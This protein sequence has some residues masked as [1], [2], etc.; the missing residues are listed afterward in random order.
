MN[1]FTAGLAPAPG[2]VPP[3]ALAG[4]P[5]PTARGLPGPVARR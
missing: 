1:P 3:A 5:D 2:P 4:P